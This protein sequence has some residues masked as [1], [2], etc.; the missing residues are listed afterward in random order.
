[1][2][3]PINPLQVWAVRVTSE[4]GNWTDRVVAESKESAER[5]VLRY[6]EKTWP[7]RHYEATA[8]RPDAGRG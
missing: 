1:M 6:L 3:S 7:G 4:Y 5:R 8:F 2:V